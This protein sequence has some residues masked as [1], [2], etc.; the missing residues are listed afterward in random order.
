M[1]Q[2]GVSL[3]GW[4]GGKREQ[5]RTGLGWGARGRMPRV[6]CTLGALTRLGLFRKCGGS[7][8]SQ[9][10]GVTDWALVSCRVSSSLWL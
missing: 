6:W 9:A 5:L 2:S 3:R 8:G 4:A 1:G 7:G 10:A